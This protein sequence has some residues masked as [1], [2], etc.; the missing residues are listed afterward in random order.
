MIVLPPTA[1]RLQEEAAGDFVHCIQQASGAR[2]PICKGA[3]PAATQAARIVI[4]P[5][6]LTRALGFAGDDLRPEE[7]RLHT[8]GNDLVVLA[9]DRF[10]DQLTSNIWGD[11][12][13]ENTRVTQWALGYLLD[14]YLGVRWLW[15]GPLGT[16]I[17]R[18]RR[19]AIP[20]LD[21][22]F[23]Q[24]L[25]RRS[26]NP[27][28]T[29]KDN[30]H[31]LNYHHFA[32]RRVNYHFSHSFR[33]GQDN[34]DWW[35]DFHQ[36]R[37]ELLAKAPSGRPEPPLRPG[38]FKLCISNPGVTD[39]IIRR[40]QAAGTPDF[41][42]VTPNDGNGFC[43]CDH[44]RALDREHG[45]AEYSKEEIW[46][47]PDH[48]GLTDRYVWFWNQ[49]I[50][51]MR[52][53][54]PRVKIGVYLYSAYRNPPK[55]LK[56]AAG[57]IGEIVHGFDFSHWV[58]WRKADVEAIGLRP[59]WLYMGASGPH[60]PLAKAGRYVEAA[61]DHNMAMISMDCFHEY[62]AT[63]GP[64]Y[65]L[66]GRLI[67]RPDL[68]AEQIIDEYCSAFGEAADAVRAYLDYWE[69]Y[70]ERVAYNIPAGG[71]VGVDEEGLY[72][73][74]SRRHFGSVM[75]PLRG[76]WKTLPYI[77][78]PA[79]LGRARQLLD[80]AQRQATGQ[81][82]VRRIDFL[83]DGLRMVELAAAYMTAHQQGDGEAMAAAV[84]ALEA[85][86][87]AMTEKHGY[88]HSKDLFFLRYWGLIG[89]E[90][91]MSSGQ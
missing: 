58:N 90:Y 15:P 22:R 1:N 71:S 12:E 40:W 60:L 51:K 16:H 35:A 36:S 50:N 49:L 6:D 31:W 42:D 59:N 74:T 4:G 8:A 55:K 82:V 34:G 83:R 2:L 72:C 77:Y 88:W 56:V 79:V 62:W 33:R 43:T 76:H 47:R 87:K 80:Q 26:F 3:P 75:H 68:K 45:G 44:C 10:H 89:E 38:F 7:F 20:P 64:Y 24:A 23:Q 30:L 11:R 14:R 86:G 13:A 81:T 53:K 70:H 19:I 84:Q 63:Q 57:I 65:Y 78:T 18:R 39:E 25:Q 48:V 28:E 27:V 54:N 66:L 67:S 61:R 46:Q 29:N 91:Q 73:Q 21:V 52:A 5:S 17:P 69:Q 32:G 85:F 9:E 41:W 37:P